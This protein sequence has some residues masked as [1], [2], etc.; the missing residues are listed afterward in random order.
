[1]TGNGSIRVLK[2]GLVLLGLFLCAAAAVAAEFRGLWVDAFGPGFFTTSQISKKGLV[3]SIANS[4]T[5]GRLTRS[6][7]SI[8][9]RSRI[10][11]MKVDR[12]IVSNLRQSRRLVN[13]E[14]PKAG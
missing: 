9:M 12:T 11:K 13:C 1:M 5:F 2:A 14:P 3:L 8:R 4:L 7:H 6:P 10:G